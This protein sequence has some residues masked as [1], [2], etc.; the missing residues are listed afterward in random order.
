MDGEDSDIHMNNPM[1][2]TDRLGTKIAAF[3]VLSGVLISSLHAKFAH[4]NERSSHVQ[5]LEVI[6]FLDK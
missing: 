2:A 5:R 1:R 6:D 4:K 3:F